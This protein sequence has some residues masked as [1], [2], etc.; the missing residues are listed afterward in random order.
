[1]PVAV[2]VEE[3]S[4]RVDLTTAPPDGYVV[5]RRMT[6]GEKLT[7]TG[8]ATQMLFE[9]GENGSRSKDTFK[10]EMKIRTEEIA[11]WDFS[12]LVIEHNLTDKNGIPLNF[13]NVE[14]VKKLHPKIGEE[15]GKIIDDFNDVENSEHVKN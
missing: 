1:M 11:L 9:Q 7:R 13:K 14:D 3:S 6:Y 2:I 8:M 4:G 12:N 10:G 15:I 5:V